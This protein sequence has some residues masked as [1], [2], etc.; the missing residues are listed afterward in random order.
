[1]RFE[2]WYRCDEVY[3]DKRDQYDYNPDQSKYKHYPCYRHFY[4]AQYA[5]TDDFF[6]FLM[7]LAYAKQASDTFEGDWSQREIRAFPTIYDTPNKAD[8]KTYTY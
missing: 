3:Y 4:E 7:E 6:D 1:L 2:R 8:R 5:C